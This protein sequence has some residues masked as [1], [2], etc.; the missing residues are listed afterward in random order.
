M[1]FNTII[2]HKPPEIYFVRKKLHFFCNFA[3]II[4]DFSTRFGYSRVHR[5]EAVNNG[6]YIDPRRGYV[7]TRFPPQTDSPPR[8]FFCAVAN[9]YLNTPDL[10]EYFPAPWPVKLTEKY[11][12]PCPENHLRVFNHYTLTAAEK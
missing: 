3:G 10:Y 6:F 7:S 12:L 4:V 8:H 9:Y 5:N 1:R 11:P 2:G